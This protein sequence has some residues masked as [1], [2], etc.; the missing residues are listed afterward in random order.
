MKI[1]LKIWRQNSSS[2]KGYFKKYPLVGNFRRYVF[3]GNDGYVK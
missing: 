3:P 1:N 2:D